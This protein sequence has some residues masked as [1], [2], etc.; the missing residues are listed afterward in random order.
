MIYKKDAVGDGDMF[1]LGAI[2]SFMG[3]RGIFSVVVIASFLGSIYGLTLIFM[4]KADRVSYMPFGPF[5]SIG[6]IINLYYFWD[7]IEFI[8]S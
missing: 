1:L 2:G 6:C 8:S 4:K 3:Y 7:F 5:L